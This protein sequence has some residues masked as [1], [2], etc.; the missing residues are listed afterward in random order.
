MVCVKVTFSLYV[1]FVFGDGTSTHQNDIRHFFSGDCDSDDQCTGNLKCFQRSGGGP[2]PPGCSCSS[3]G[4]SKQVEGLPAPK[5]F[6]LCEVIFLTFD[7]LCFLSLTQIPTF[8]MIPMRTRELG[9]GEER[10]E[11]R[12]GYYS[13]SCHYRVFQNKFYLF[14]PTLSNCTSTCIHVVSTTSLLVL[15]HKNPMSQPSTV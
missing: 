4:S 7:F 6:F 2:C 14:A 13:C 1:M 8:V 5:H 3:L 9:M 15:I 12:F 11:G 10:R